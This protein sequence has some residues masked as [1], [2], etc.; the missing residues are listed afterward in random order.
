MLGIISGLPEN[1][2]FQLILI[3][4]FSFAEGRGIHGEA[5]D[6]VTNVI[7]PAFC[8]AGRAV[9]EGILDGVGEAHKQV[10]DCCFG[11]VDTRLIPLL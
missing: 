1:A 5:V 11:G 9:F 10:W 3:P 6:G 8:A 2:R 7:P 4:P